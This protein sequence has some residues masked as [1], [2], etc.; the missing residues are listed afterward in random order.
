[1]SVTDTG[2][3]PATR[4]TTGQPK[5]RAPRRGNMMLGLLAWLIGI[6][7][8]IPIFWMVLTSLHIE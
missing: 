6:V 2:P 4:T 1:M 7:F 8:I 5:R 3:I